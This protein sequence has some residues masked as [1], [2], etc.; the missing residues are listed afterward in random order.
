LNDRNTNSS[1]LPIGDASDVAERSSPTDRSTVAPVHL[2]NT[3]ATCDVL[4]NM[5]VAS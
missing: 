5:Y 2:R 1:H 4:R 3:V